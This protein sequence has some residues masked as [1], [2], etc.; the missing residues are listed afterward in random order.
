MLAVVCGT[1]LL[2]YVSNWQLTIGNGCALERR[3]GR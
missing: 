1:V 2:L 3:R